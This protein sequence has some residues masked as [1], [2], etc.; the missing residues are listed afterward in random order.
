M[1]HFLQCD[2]TCNN[3]IQS[4]N[5]LN[6][7]KTIFPFTAVEV[8][9]DNLAS[10]GLFTTQSIFRKEYFTLV[11][12]LFNFHACDPHAWCFYFEML[13]QSWSHLTWFCCFTWKKNG[14]IILPKWKYFHA[15]LPSFVSWCGNVSPPFSLNWDH[16]DS[17]IGETTLASRS[18]IRVLMEPPLSE[19]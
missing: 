1:C 10:C 18:I 11:E 17:L 2:N 16:L 14:E 6:S 15:V 3:N 13:V 7:I 5:K 19:L 9:G 8:K 12:Q 4:S